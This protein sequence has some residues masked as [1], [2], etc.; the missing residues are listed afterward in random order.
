MYTILSL[1]GRSPFAPL[2]SHMDKVESCIDKLIPLFDA[3]E[4]KEYATVEKIALEISELEHQ[5]DITKN[6]IRKH[7]PKS[8]FLPVDRGN[9]LEILSL[10]DHLADMAE[11]I[12]VLVSLKKL[13]LP[14]S[15]KV[16]FRE[17]LIKNI[18]TFKGVRKIIMELHDLLE[19]SFGG[20]E[21]VTVRQMVEEVAY[22]EHEVD[23][24][25]R[26]LL[27]HLYN[28]ENE[29]TFASFHLW[30]KIFEHTASLSNISEKLAY[31]VGMTLD[32]KG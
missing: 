7:L 15:L 22:K 25:Q 13:E 31:R 32:L 28:A 16:E 9:L 18:D 21:A 10:Q 8:L 19:S 11:D 30:Q 4:K 27:K 23:L 26:N 1:F 14:A 24:L 17:F 3:L 29:L 5:A 2:Q 20:S 6:D 12:A